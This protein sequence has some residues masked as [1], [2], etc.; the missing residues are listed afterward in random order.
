MIDDTIRFQQ[1]ANA[2]STDLGEDTAVLN[3]QNGAYLGL[4]VTASFVWRELEK[5]ST[6]A[7]LSRRLATVFAVEE[8]VCAAAVERLLKQL[9]DAGVVMRLEAAAP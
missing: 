7:Q 6:T 9:V 1:V 4:N 5:A 3:M 8:D 2:V